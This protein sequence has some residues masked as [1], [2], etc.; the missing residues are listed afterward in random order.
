MNSVEEVNAKPIENLIEEDS[1]IEEVEEVKKV[2]EVESKQPYVIKEH[3]SFDDM[4]LKKKL[5]RGIYSYGFEKPS[6]IQKKGIIPMTEG[7][8]CI[9]QAQAGTGKT[10]TFIIG[11][12][13]VIDEKLPE[14]QAIIVSHTRELAEQTLNVMN[15]IG[16]YL[17]IKTT[18]CVGGKSIKHSIKEIKNGAQIVSGTPGRLIHMIES[19][20]INLDHLK[21]TIIDE[22]DE[23][24]SEGFMEQLEVIIKNIPGSSQICIFSATIP[25]EIKDIS[26]L[27]LN[28]PVKIFVKKEELTLEGIRQFYVDV[29]QEDYKLPTLCDLF[30]MISISQ[31]IIYINEIKKANEVYKELKERSYTAS[32]IHS[33]MDQTE[34]S[35]IIKD[36]R[37]GTVRTLISTDLMARGIDIQQV[38]IVINYDLPSMKNKAS[39]IHRIGRS[40]RFGRKGVAISFA[41]T[42]DNSKLRALESYYKTE[43]KEMP[44]PD[45][46]EKML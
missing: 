43:I 14:V 7:K 8:D 6:A 4:H 10:G 13:Q 41:T 28:D 34:R 22:A 44:S 5:L 26:K 12:M 45:E 42:G 24:L 36:F 32:V 25:N 40:G 30:K 9:F 11:S 2:E 35:E 1:D 3:E 15:G 19:G 31:S 29:V 20:L 17:G 16:S 37:R 38:S 21:I 39:Y 18:L 46:I 27:F 23:L 33:G